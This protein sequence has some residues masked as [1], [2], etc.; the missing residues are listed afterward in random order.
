MDIGSAVGRQKGVTEEQLMALAEHASSEVYTPAEKVALR[1]ADAMAATPTVVSD[2]LFAELRRHFDEPQLVELASAIAWEHNRAR[3]N[4][5]FD[6]QSDEFSEGAF[7]VI[8]ARMPR[9][10]APE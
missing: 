5:V 2:E 8:P 9:L 6:I 4:K 10:M 1:L 3:F 7:C